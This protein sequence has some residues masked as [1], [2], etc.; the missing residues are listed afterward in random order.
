[1]GVTRIEYKIIPNIE[2]IDIIIALDN[3]NS[4]LVAYSSHF[5]F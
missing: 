3:E 4:F 2:I 1:M 5:A